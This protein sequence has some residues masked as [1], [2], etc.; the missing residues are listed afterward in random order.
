MGKG[1]EALERIKDNLAVFVNDD[2]HY[3]DY[4][5]DINL[6]EKEL[7]ALEIINKKDIN[8]GAF[9]ELDLEHYNMYA[10]DILGLRPLTQEEYNLLNEV[11]YVT[12]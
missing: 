3:E 7:K 2:Y 6:I 8:V 11:L 10:R 1:L 12:R 4:A 5:N 9:K